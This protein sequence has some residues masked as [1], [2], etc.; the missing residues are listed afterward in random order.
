MGSGL[1]AEEHFDLLDVPQWHGAKGQCTVRL[2]GTVDEHRNR[3]VES[4]RALVLETGYRYAADTPVLITGLVVDTWRSGEHVDEVVVLLLA[5]LLVGHHD[6]TR[7]GLLQGA[8]DF[9]H[10]SR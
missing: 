10:P 9:F 8:V 6:D 5:Q 1:R 2:R 4:G 3:A 7:L